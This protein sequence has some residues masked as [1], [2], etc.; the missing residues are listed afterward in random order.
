MAPPA[1]FTVQSA[2]V[3][4]ASK[5]GFLT[6]LQIAVDVTTAVVVVLVK[7]AVVERDVTVVTVIAEAIVFAGQHLASKSYPTAASEIII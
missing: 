7:K 5:L 1:V 6:T 3:N 4:G 2:A